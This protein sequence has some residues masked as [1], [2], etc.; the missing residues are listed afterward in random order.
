M[1]SWSRGQS[2]WRSQSVWPLTSAAVTWR[3]TLVWEG[4]IEDKESSAFH[5]HPVSS[6][7][8]L[9]SGAER[10]SFLGS[11]H[12]RLLRVR[13]LRGSLETKTRLGCELTHYLIF[14]GNVILLAMLGL[15]SRSVE[16]LE[17]AYL[18]SP[19]KAAWCHIACERKMSLCFFCSHVTKLLG[20]DFDFACW[21]ID[22]KSIFEL[23]SLKAVPSQYVEIPS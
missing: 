9:D 4:L 12:S 8:Q 1:R 10:S 23:S 20:K 14:T 13:C 19:F 6:V 16:N 7:G 22:F 2:L 18:I 21:G 17:S 5:T 11:L 3:P 15:W